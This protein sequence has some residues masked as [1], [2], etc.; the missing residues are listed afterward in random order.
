MQNSKFKMQNSK[1]RMQNAKCG[2]EL[3][4]LCRL[5]FLRTSAKCASTSALGLSSVF[6][7]QLSVFRFPLLYSLIRTLTVGIGISPIQSSGCLRGSF[8]PNS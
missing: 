7:F 3:I 2:K 6:R 8:K 4:L 1:S 5:F